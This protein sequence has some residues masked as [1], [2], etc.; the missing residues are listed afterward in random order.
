[1]ECA[2]DCLWATGIPLSDPSCLDETKWLS[3][4][5]LGQMLE[6]IRNDQVLHL[7]SSHGYQSGTTQP[8]LANNHESSET[9]ALRISNLNLPICSCT[10]TDMCLTHSRH[11]SPMEGLSS[12]ME[13]Q[14]DSASA[15]TTPVSDT[16]ETDTDSGD[17]HTL[18][19][20]RLR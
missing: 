19:S 4:G 13:T 10:Q 7:T 2:T 11:I 8:T 15:S 5:I 12:V 16:T 20:S 1:M 9:S 17:S 6:S 18:P 14:M 3:P